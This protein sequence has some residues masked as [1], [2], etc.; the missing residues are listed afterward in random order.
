M[1]MLLRIAVLLCVETLGGSSRNRPM[2]QTKPSR[3]KN[4]SQKEI[5]LEVQTSDREIAKDKKE[6]K[7]PS[8][9]LSEEDAKAKKDDE[10]SESVDTSSSGS[11]WPQEL[12]SA[13]FW[14]KAESFR[15]RLMKG[16]R[17]EVYSKSSK[18][19]VSAFVRNIQIDCN[20]EN[21]LLV[22]YNINGK[23]KY[24]EVSLDSE[25]LRQSIITDRVVIRKTMEIL[26]Q[27][28][29]DKLLEENTWEFTFEKPGTSLMNSIKERTA[30]YSFRA[31]VREH[32][33]FEVLMFKH[34][35]ENIW[36]LAA[37]REEYPG[38]AE[39]LIVRDGMVEWEYPDNINLD[40]LGRLRK[41]LY[42]QP[43]Y[44]DH[45]LVKWPP[46]FE[47]NLE[48]DYL[49]AQLAMDKEVLITCSKILNIRIRRNQ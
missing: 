11:E 6:S 44:D 18:M 28:P 8:W 20:G 13:H 30:I 10:F 27:I 24:K 42:S 3:K 16:S 19:W 48:S 22:N 39:M 12:D 29:E 35:T 9:G 32:S 41:E 45:M 21:F 26:S 37:L 33:R 36:A 43:N 25:Y 14:F 46:R 1:A 40:F 7:L 2:S 17:V 34:R 47:K 49:A 38:F 15:H 5:P 4:A 23:N 31:I